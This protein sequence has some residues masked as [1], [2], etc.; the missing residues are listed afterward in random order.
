MHEAKTIIL[1]IILLQPR[2]FAQGKM[3]GDD[4]C[5]GEFT[6][7]GYKIKA[8]HCGSIYHMQVPLELLW[9]PVT[10][11]KSGTETTSMTGGDRNRDAVWG[12][13]PSKR[14]HIVYP[15]IPDLEECLNKP[16][17]DAGNSSLGKICD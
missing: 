4:A 9:A 7:M 1:W 12:G 15:Y 10:K 11:Q 13:H 3:V 16:I 5:L 2:K 17:K 6:N 8:K 14:Q